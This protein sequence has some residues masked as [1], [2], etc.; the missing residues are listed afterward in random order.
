MPKS[1]GTAACLLADKTPP[2]SNSVVA[3]CREQGFG[4]PAV[5]RQAPCMLCTGAFQP[6]PNF[7]YGIWLEAKVVSKGFFY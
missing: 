7:S 2:C 5:C 4:S 6:Q 1:K 3:L